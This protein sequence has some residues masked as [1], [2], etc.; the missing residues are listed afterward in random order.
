MAHQTLAGFMA[1]Y[2]PD[3]SRVKA[4]IT[5]RRNAAGDSPFI[6]VRHGEFTAVLALMPFDDHLCIDV[7]SFTGGQDAAAGVFGMTEGCRVS[8]PDVT[9][10]RS[11]GWAAAGTVSVIVGEQDG[12]ADPAAQRKEAADLA[13]ALT[14]I[15]KNGFGDCVD[16]DSVI[17]AAARAYLAIIR[18]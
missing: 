14:E 2:D 17:E 3:G 15:G 4:E 8:F 16:D 13:A 9:G 7:H 10:V 18:R 6:V 12:E 5:A 1:A 11:H